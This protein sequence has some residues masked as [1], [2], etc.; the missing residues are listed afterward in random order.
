MSPTYCHIGREGIVEEF[1]I[2]HWHWEPQVRREIQWA[3]AL[4]NIF[5]MVDILTMRIMVI[6]SRTQRWHF[7]KGLPINS[8]PWPQLVFEP[9]SAFPAAYHR[10]IPTDNRP[11]TA[12]T[13]AHIA[14]HKCLPS[15]YLTSFW[16]SLLK[17][18]K[19]STLTIILH[20][21]SP[22]YTHASF[23]QC[24][25]TKKLLSYIRESGPPRSL[26][27]LGKIWRIGNSVD[28]KYHDNLLFPIIL[29]I[30]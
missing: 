10:G 8:A 14:L 22:N 23:S 17:S 12:E 7:D 29:R 5:G 15:A 30:P 6:V 11:L 4:C 26:S 2:E 25:Q 13:S 3:S 27:S 19:T 1:S 16:L 20:H 9:H 18:V 28:I 24:D 21:S